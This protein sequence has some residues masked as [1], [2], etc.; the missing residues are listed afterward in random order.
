MK[1]TILGAI[2]GDVIGSFYEFCPVKTTNFQLFPEASRFTDDTVMTVA[3]ADWILTHDSLLGVMQVYGNRHSNVG[4]G[5]M[6]YEWL[7]AY[8]PMPYNSWGNRSAM[9]VSPV[10][11]AFNTLEETLEAAKVSAEI[12]HNHSE[13]IKG[14]QATAAAIYMAR[15]GATKDEI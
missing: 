10:G 13:G 4:Y 2:A 5:G 9:R 12:T 6:F 8:D 1:A 3:V 11:F 15:S 14:A 7:N